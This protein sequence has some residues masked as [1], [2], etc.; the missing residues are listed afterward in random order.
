[1]T[2]RVRWGIVGPG[3]IARNVV[4][5]FA[6]V[7]NATVV[8]VGSRSRARASDFADEHG[9]WRSYGSYAEIVA[10]PDVDVLYLA[11][12]HPQHHPVAIAALH[13]GKALLVEKSFTATIPGAEQI[14][15]LART[16]GTFVM[17]AMWTRFQPA[18][19]AARTLVDDGAIGEVRQVGRSGRRPAL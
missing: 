7:P 16:T 13:S 6:H 2:S 18:M 4:K 9:I 1:M 19:V 11:T 8:A 17:E 12:P 3:R 15:E 14:I 10:D 5:D